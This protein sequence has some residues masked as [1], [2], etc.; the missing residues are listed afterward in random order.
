L[1]IPIGYAT[2][3]LI[4]DPTTAGEAFDERHGL[5]D[6]FT[7]LHMPTDVKVIYNGTNPYAVVTA[8]DDDKVS[9]I[10]LSDPNN[11]V[12]LSTVA[13]QQTT[14]LAVGFMAMDAPKALQV[15]E[16]TTSPSS[17]YYAAV[18][19][20]QND[21]VQILDLGNPNDISTDS[22]SIYNATDSSPAGSTGG[23]SFESHGARATAGHFNSATPMN[24]ASDIALLNNGSDA[25]PAYFVV[26]SGFLGD[27]IQLY[28]ARD[29]GD[30]GGHFEIAGNIS[31]ANQPT[32]LTGQT[33]CGR[34]VLDGVTAVDT[35][36]MTNTTVSRTQ[37]YGIAVAQAQDGVQ[38]FSLTN[39]YIINGGTNATSAT[40]PLLDG[41]NDVATWDHY[42]TPHAIITSNVT[43]SV[44]VFDL[45]GGAV[46]EEAA[47]QGG[48][49][50]D[51]NQQGGATCLKLT[52]SLTDSEGTNLALDGA[53]R[54]EIVTVA[55]RTYAIISANG[56]AGNL[57][58][59]GGGG[60]PTA[61]GIQI[62][63]VSD[64][65][66]IDPVASIFGNSTNAN[67]RGGFGLDTFILGDHTYIVVAN[68][69]DDA[70]QVIQLTG[71]EQGKGNNAVCGVNRDCSA[72][73]INSESDGFSINNTN[74]ANTDRFNDVDETESTVGK[75]VTIKARIYDSFGTSA[76]EKANLYF[77]MPN[78]PE[79]SLANA[80][81]E[82]DVQR[83]SINIQDTNDIFDADVTTKVV[84]DRLEVTYK[85]MF[86]DEMSTSH[87][88]MQTVDVA[89]NYQLLYFKDALTVVGQS[90]GPTQTSAD[91][92]IGDEVTQTTASVPAWVKN[93]AGWWAEG[94]I[95]EVEFVKGVE[96][97]IK[98]QIID[99]SVQTT[100]STGTGSSVPD[101]VKN[102]AGWWAEGEI[103][104]GEF[105]NAIEHLVKTGTI[106]V[107]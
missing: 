27:G 95:S 48:C 21:G 85:I 5:G 93:T 102:T 10:D 23:G 17:G 11:P 64:P 49:T 101:W 78:V 44:Q 36:S 39:P 70:L 32:C 60:D 25:S 1:I 41:A 29:V 46:I 99:T 30:E 45:S 35:F 100:T 72:P 92:T 73:S 98:Q 16:N 33:S 8:M 89:K 88:A 82:Y 53:N 76:I 107:I 94:K 52:D 74:L 38:V 55:E 87:V 51:R 104:E 71:I 59:W 6:S 69:F 20:N 77:D 50:P 105:V 58:A 62:I 63:D 4:I 9:I 80:A 103:S 86:T 91:E 67:S 19:S 2:A 42:G 75:L 47:D 40:F 56:T 90:T 84:G 106:I 31:A 3:G 96:F 83:D 14:A 61:G 68:A 24:G 34:H 79:W 57:S 18:A 54:V 81:I 7:G 28:N 26:V 43:D 37:S 15:W 66:N 22:R 13:D 12:E 65:K 97:L